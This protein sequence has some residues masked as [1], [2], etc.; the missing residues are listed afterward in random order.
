MLR[1][2]P[3]T[4]MS[5]S[6]LTP[7]ASALRL[8]TSA[9]GDRLRAGGPGYA[10][11]EDFISPTQVKLLKRDVAHL[12]EHGQFNVAG[13]GDSS[14]NRV[15][16]DVRRCEQSFLFPKIKYEAS[17]TPDSRKMLYPLLDDLREKLASNTGEALEP[18][19]TEGA[20]MSYPNGG[21]YRR[22]IDSLAGTATSARAISFI[23]YLTDPSVE[24][25]AAHG[26]ALR[27]YDVPCET[28]ES[29][30]RT[31]HRDILPASGLLVLFDSALISFWFR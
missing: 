12:A 1:S 29:S 31:A 4:L 21:F 23:C 14:T 5:L 25:V 3:V 22:H 8:P 30:S 19:L 24:W 26:G 27:A 17:G 11:V 7:R 20:Y 13:V 16:T 6:L 18:L 2:V 28:G 9:I 15:A 10:V